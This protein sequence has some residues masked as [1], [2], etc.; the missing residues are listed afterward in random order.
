M[1]VIPATM[2]WCSLKE[3]FLG[4]ER[5]IKGF[6]GSRFYKEDKEG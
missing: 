6:Y 5:A 4:P 3:S 1:V 2:W